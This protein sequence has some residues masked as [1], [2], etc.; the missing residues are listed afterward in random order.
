MGRL[1]LDDLLLLVEPRLAHELADST[2]LTRIHSLAA[3][4]PASL[5]TFFGFERRLGKQ[6]GLDFA[7]SL[8]SYG[9]D[10][11][12]LSNRWPQL[13]HLVQSW[14]RQGTSDSPAV[15]LEFDT[16]QDDASISAPNVFIAS[17]RTTWDRIDTTAALES[18]IEACPE[19]VSRLLLGFMF[20]RK[21]RAV[22]LCAVPMNCAQAIAFLRAVRWPGDIGNAAAT[23]APY[24]SLCDAICVQVDL[25]EGVQPSAGFELLYSGRERDW[26]YPREK[27]WLALF[28]RL[29]SDGLCLSDERDAL[30][31]WISTQRFEAPLVDRLIAAA[32]P[33]G[34]AI[35]HGTLYTG[36]QHVKLSLGADGA[37]LAKAYFGA[38][39]DSDG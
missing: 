26:Q 20:S 24:A 18:C 7:L 5:A 21:T 17:D 9:L 23:I 22:R 33:R 37:L 19:S 35:L 13:S 29:V 8:S 16:S 3:S 15:W 14:P 36:L 27:R 12:S 1:T 25:C 4:L 10:W 32:S 11:L 31:G 6:A 34:E 28:T 30:L 39:L 2:S 38:L